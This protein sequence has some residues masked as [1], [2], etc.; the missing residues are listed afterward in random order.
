MPLVTIAMVSNATI[1]FTTPSPDLPHGPATS[2]TT[3]RVI[4]VAVTKAELL[5]LASDP[6]VL[7]WEG[8]RLS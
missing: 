3:P 6:R 2:V 4:I 8:K 1:P 5:G 7:G